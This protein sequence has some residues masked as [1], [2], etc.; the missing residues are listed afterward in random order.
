MMAKAP[1]SIQHIQGQ[2]WLILSLGQYQIDYGKHVAI[3]HLEQSKLKLNP[4]LSSPKEVRLVSL[5][6]HVHRLDLGEYSIF[7]NKRVQI[8]KQL[9]LKDK[10]KG[11]KNK[12]YSFFKDRLSM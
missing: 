12:L 9:I 6:E 5:E 10:H 1:S 11:M 4:N 7:I 3:L 8:P 2:Y